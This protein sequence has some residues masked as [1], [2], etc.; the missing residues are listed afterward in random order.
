MI[1]ASIERLQ[2]PDPSEKRMALESLY[3]NCCDD[4]VLESA[5]YLLTDPD[6]GVRE[7]ASHVLILCSSEKAASLAAVHISSRNI[8]VRNL[9][10]DAL[11]RMGESAIP[12]LLP[13][14]DSAD[15][16]VRKFAV[17]LIAQLP[18]T[19]ASV[20]KIAVHL[21]DPDQNVVCASIDALGAM[22]AEQH[23]PK[24]LRLFDKAEYA[25]P[26][27]VNAAAKFE[28][29]VSFQFF[30]KALSDEDPVVQLASA[31]AL[32]S[33]KDKELL[34]IL[35][36]KMT[37][38][39]DLAKP[40]I[41]HSIVILMES[42]GYRGEM[43]A[44]LKQSLLAMLDDP[45][46]AYMRAAVRGLQNFIDDNVLTALVSHAGKGESVDAS[47]LGVLRD[48]P[49]KA[50]RIALARARSTGEFASTT[51]LMISL[52]HTLQENDSPRSVG[53]VLDEA[54]GFIAG[55]FSRLDADM[56]ITA[57]SICGS[58]G[59]P[60]AIR[61]IRSALEDR[62]SAVKSL[63]LDLAARTGPQ[64]FGKELQLLKGDYDEEIR[65]AAT[66]LMT[67]GKPG[68]PNQD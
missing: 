61:L 67:Q 4:R 37:S 10:G 11:V 56:K 5:A 58:L 12:A 49:E 30:V 32:S 65:F 39:S 18:A 68:L 22:H 31:E 45:D 43:P 6:R 53:G 2:T 66:A 26:N 59:T 7:A 27:V 29:G 36:A 63:A 19:P 35:L 47:I 20:A 62:E 55:N 21:N 38:V 24:I 54:A 28:K 60:T 41:L 64:H 15:K 13:Y 14:V 23:L 44:Y 50:I 34:N 1:E 9:A 46:P 33:R 25:R 52:I 40:V 51:V 17:D 16:D 57:L 3:E 8:A 48:Y 42:T